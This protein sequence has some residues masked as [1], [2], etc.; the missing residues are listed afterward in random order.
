MKRLTFFF[1]FLIWTN[2]SVA[3]GAFFYGLGDLPGGNYESAAYAISGNGKV[4]V[5]SSSSATS[6]REQ[7]FVWTAGGGMQPLEYTGN[8]R[9]SANAVSYDGSTIVGWSGYLSSTPRAIEWTESGART[10]GGSRANAISDDGSIVA[11]MISEVN[12][13]EAMYWDTSRNSYG[14]GGREVGGISANGQI[15]VGVDG[16]ST[17]MEAVYWN[18]SGN[19]IS[20]GLGGEYEFAIAASSDGSVVIGSGSFNSVRQAFIWK[21]GGD[22]KLIDNLPNGNGY[23]TDVS[24]NGSIVVGYNYLAGGG[25]DAFV[26]DEINGTRRL[27]DILTDLG[28]EIDGWNLDRVTGISENGILVGYG[29]NPQGNT[30]AWI[31]SIPE[32]TTLLLLGMGGLLMRKHK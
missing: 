23:A 30:E 4:V 27:Y 8:N 15:M 2:I 20:L 5:G 24:Y 32:P 14:L 12:H 28:V 25:S 22:W 26:W 1:A 10:I 11:G 18:Q 29:I 3:T 31:A 13:H 7:A 17:D 21:M 19:M 6:D 9:T 16:Y